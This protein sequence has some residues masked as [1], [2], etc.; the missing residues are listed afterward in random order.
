MEVNPVNKVAFHSFLKTYNMYPTRKKEQINY[1]DTGR[2]CPVDGVALQPLDANGIVLDW[3][4]ECC[5]IFFDYGELQEVL[6]L[7]KTPSSLAKN[8]VEMQGSDNQSLSC[9][10][11]RVPM[12]ARKIPDS[13]RQLDICGSCGGIWLDGGEFMLLYKEAHGK[14]AENVIRSI[15]QNFFNLEI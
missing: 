8:M 10:R 14:D 12:T 1:I 4:A 11:C 13:T 5:G 9:P 2:H 6:Q 7:D 15:V 3:C